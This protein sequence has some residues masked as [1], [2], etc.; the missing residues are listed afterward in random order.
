MIAATLLTT[1]RLRAA[2]PSAADQ[3]AA[4]ALFREAQGMIAAGRASEACPKFEA[5][6]RLEPT[7][8]TQ[9]NL[10]DCYERVGRTASAFGMFQDS[11]AA[12]RKAGDKARQQAALARAKALEGK[13]SRLT[14]LVAPANRPPGLEVKQ[15]GRP[16]VEAMWGSAIPVDPGEHAMEAWAP[17]RVRWRGTAVVGPDGAVAM[18]GIP[19]LAAA[20]LPPGWWGAQRVAGVAVAGAGVAGAIVGAVFGARAISKNNASKASCSPTDSNLCNDTGVSLRHDAKT[21]GTVSTAALAAGGAMVVGGVVL[22]FTAPSPKPAETARIVVMPR[23]ARGDV[24]LMIEG[25]W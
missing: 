25:R 20:P 7:V 2:E 21:A 17:G 1:P 15:D 10:A 6:Q 18:V 9:L 4:D 11:E 3:A 22:F 8:G 5:A 14:I 12:A 24:G 23:V 13:L 16:V 19:E